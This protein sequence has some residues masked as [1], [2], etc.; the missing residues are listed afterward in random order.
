M[1]N[2]VLIYIILFIYLPYHLVFAQ[3]KVK[4]S[5]NQDIIQITQDGKVGIGI[6]PNYP[7]HVAKSASSSWVARF[8]NSVSGGADLYIGHSNNGLYLDAGSGA[9]TSNYAMMVTQS[10]AYPVPFLYINSYNGHIG[11]GTSNVSG[12]NNAHVVIQDTDGYGELMLRDLNSD[13][14]V[15][16]WIFDIHS[17]DHEH[18]DVQSGYLSLFTNSDR[19]STINFVNMGT[20][21][22]R[23]LLEDNLTIGG[24]YSPTPRGLLDV[25]GPLYATLNT[26]TGTQVVINNEQLLI[27]S[28]SVRHKQDI[29]PFRTQ[30]DNILKVE[31]VSFKY[32]DTQQEDI[33][34]LAEELDRIGLKELVHYENGQPFSIKYDKITLY[35]IEV[36]KEMK[37]KLDALEQVRH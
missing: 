30:F 13:S 36:I 8:T 1:K 37:S 4:N 33:G 31:P 5:A 11:I 16:E 18:G 24:G 35:L 34:Y 32:K 20:G 17:F 26:G 21:K 27:S 14:Y 28:S 6:A 29:R 3:L 25:R 19:N 2:R 15:N 23:M 10:G 22:M 9:T 7:F 12:A